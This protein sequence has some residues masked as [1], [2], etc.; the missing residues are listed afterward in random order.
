MKNR[1]GIDWDEIIRKEFV[2][3]LAA[4]PNFEE[5]G[6]LLIGAGHIWQGRLGAGRVRGR[7][8]MSIGHK[9]RDAGQ[10][11]RHSAL[12]WSPPPEWTSCYSRLLADFRDHRS[13]MSPHRNE[14]EPVFKDAQAARLLAA[15]AAA[16]IQD[17]L[18]VIG[19]TG[20]H[21][22]RRDEVEHWE[23]LLETLG[24]HPAGT[25]PDQPLSRENLDLFGLRA[26][27]RTC[28]GL[29]SSL[30]C[31]WV[32]AKDG[33]AVAA[34]GEQARLW[35]AR[36]EAYRDLAKQAYLRFAA[37]RPDTIRQALL[38][39]RDDAGAYGFTD[40]HYADR[41]EIAASEKLAETI[42][43]ILLQLAGERYG[44]AD[45]ADAAAILRR[46][47]FPPPPKPEFLAAADGRKRL[48]PAK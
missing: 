15:A 41:A 17:Q 21:L 42:I 3:R 40:Q 2:S 29:C 11:W 46:T 33:D 23:D 30:C 14:G 35:G 25:P 32:Y 24:E 36:S 38:C 34:K 9:L 18:P 22:Y 13:F 12:G 31:V 7:E 4:A 26:A 6:S 37:G 39:G 27:Y 5:A 28:E 43:G 45:A 44:R 10:N 20:Q 19:V 48:P 1:F 16:L 47:E 8:L